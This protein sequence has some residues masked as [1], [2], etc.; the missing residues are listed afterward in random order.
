M[1]SSP[2]NGALRMG[3]GGAQDPSALTTQQLV[4]ENFWLRELIE[5]RLNGMDKAI[6]LLQAAADRVPSLSVVDANV[7]HLKELVEEKFKDGKTA[8]DAAMASQGKAIDKQ[9]NAFSEQI[10]GIEKRQEADKKATDEKITDIKDRVGAVENYAKGGAAMWGMII[11]GLG[12]L[13][14]A[15]SL[16]VLFVKT[17]A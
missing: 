7:K 6:D 16:I 9:E 15:T 3:T 4:R 2:D 14:A 13:V 1:D 11:G 12:L 5:T 10:G 8:L 17:S